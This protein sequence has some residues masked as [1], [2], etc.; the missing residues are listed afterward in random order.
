M[1][2]RDLVFIEIIRFSLISNKKNQPYSKSLL[3]TI[4]LLTYWTISIFESNWQIWKRI[5]QKYVSVTST[6]TRTLPIFTGICN[7]EIQANYV[8]IIRIFTYIKYTYDDS[9]SQKVHLIATIS[10][11]AWYM[12][13]PVCVCQFQRNSTFSC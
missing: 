3:V 10:M 8:E 9:S 11:Y 1:K 7:I 6:L 13:L 2:R 5:W 12:C 4:L